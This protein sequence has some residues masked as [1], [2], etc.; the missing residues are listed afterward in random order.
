MIEVASTA[1]AA[2][3][4]ADDESA[5]AIAS[6][7]AA[8]LYEL[9]VLKSKI[10]DNLANFTRFL[11]IST[12]KVKASGSDKTSLMFALKDEPGILY[13]ALRPFDAH[14]VNMTKIESRPSKKK[15]WEYIFFIDLDGHVDSETVQ[16]SIDAL[17]ASCLVVKVLG[18]YPRARTA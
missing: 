8:Q 15:P 9:R 7:L 12:R 14:K 17:R 3:M 2:Q 5:A 13:R 16:A 1:L 18:S 6:E 11:V 10:E 4:A